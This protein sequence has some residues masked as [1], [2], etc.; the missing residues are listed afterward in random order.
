MRGCGTR[1]DSGARR[2]CG[3]LKGSGPRFLTRRKRRRNRRNT[4][5]TGGVRLTEY[6][7]LAA[8]PLTQRRRDAEER[9]ALRGGWSWRLAAIHWVSH[10]FVDGSIP[11]G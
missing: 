11:G 8:S 1:R 2:E 4:E 3:V 9:G 7:G 6:P 10:G 5:K